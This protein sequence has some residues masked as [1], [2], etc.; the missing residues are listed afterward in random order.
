MPKNKPEG[1]VP[2]Y[3][4]WLPNFPKDLSPIGYTQFGVSAKQRSDRTDSAISQLVTL[5]QRENSP[6]VIERGRATR[7]DDSIVELV[8]CYWG[9][10]GRQQDFLKSDNFESWFSSEDAL[11][12][13]FGRWYESA[14]MDMDRTETLYSHKERHTGYSHYKEDVR[15]SDLHGYWGAARDRIEAS[16]ND[17]L[18]GIEFDMQQSQ[19][20]ESRGAVVEV[21]LPNNLC[22]IRT[23]QVWANSSEWERELYLNDVQPNLIKGSE[24][25]DA[26]PVETACFGSLYV[27]ELELDGTSKEKTCV[28]AFFRSLADLEEWTHNHPSH[29]AIFDSALQMMEKLKGSIDL[30]LWH[31]VTVFP[32]GKL[33][34]RYANC[35]P[36]MRFLPYFPGKVVQT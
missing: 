5:L 34:A 13:D 21:S 25:L 8:F 18:K 33:Q 31:E 26:N 1:H 35:T 9:D 6:E 12:S 19:T 20:P 14:T 29:H 22:L 28:L 23:T 4:S 7:A 15:P 17:E 36:D 11:N 32:E 16:E 3:E 2:P 10:V 24:F 30:D 27:E